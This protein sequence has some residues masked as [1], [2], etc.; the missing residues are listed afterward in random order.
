M[1]PKPIWPGA[2]LSHLLLEC[3]YFSKNFPYL[4]QFTYKEQ[5]STTTV[6]E[7]IGAVQ[8]WTVPV[9]VQVQVQYRTVQ[10]RTNTVQN[11]IVK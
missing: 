3:I 1:F 8:C 6:Q 4:L 9:Q 10:Y 5:Y 7:K 2:P 11:S